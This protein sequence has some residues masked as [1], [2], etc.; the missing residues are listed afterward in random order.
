MLLTRTWLYHT[1]MMGRGYRP[2]TDRRAGLR[3]PAVTRTVCRT[4]AARETGSRAGEK[5]KEWSCYG[6]NEFTS[7]E[8]AWWPFTWWIFV[9]RYRR[10]VIL[11]YSAVGGKLE[12]ALNRVWELLCWIFIYIGQIFLIVWIAVRSCLIWRMRPIYKWC[13]THDP[14]FPFIFP[15]R[16]SSEHFLGDIQVS[17]CLKKNDCSGLRVDVGSTSSEHRQP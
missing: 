9:G 13:S 1:L 10:Q 2:V 5:G 14:D 11:F 7:R 16:G 8:F 3:W 15:L 4:E 6:E 17:V 12:T